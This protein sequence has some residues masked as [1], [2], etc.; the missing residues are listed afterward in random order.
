MRMNKTFV[1]GPDNFYRER[2]KRGYSRRW[3]D[4]QL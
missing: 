3:L 2:F 1:N 4:I